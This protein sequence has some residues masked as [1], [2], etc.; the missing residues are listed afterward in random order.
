[1]FTYDCVLAAVL[2]TSPIESTELVPH[3]EL[4]QP[5][6]LQLAIDAEVLDPREEQY[7][8]C[9]SNDLA[10]DWRVLR[11]RFDHLLNAPSLFECDRFPDRKRIEDLLCFNRDYRKDLHSSLQLDPRYADEVRTAIAEVDQRYYVWTTLRDARTPF[12]YVTVRRQ[13]MMHLRDLLGAEAFY[14]SELP[15]PVPLDHFPRMK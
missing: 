7:L 10:G 3:L 4:V 13:A 6:F 12:Y 5:T 11:K 8:E 1:M 9:L 2:L 15:A 14:R